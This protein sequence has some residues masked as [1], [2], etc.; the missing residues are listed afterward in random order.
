M[1]T[2]DSPGAPRGGRFLLPLLLLAAAP[3]PGDVADA[4]GRIRDACKAEENADTA[5]CDCYVDALKAALPDDSFAAM[6]AFAAATLGDDPA[7]LAAVIDAARED[8]DRYNAM[9]EAMKTATAQAAEVCG[10]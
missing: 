6:M 9:L 8:P 1:A 2:H 3:A 10:R 7:A 4:E 5:K